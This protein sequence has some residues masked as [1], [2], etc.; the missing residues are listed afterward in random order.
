MDLVRFVIAVVKQR[1]YVD[2]RMDFWVGIV[3]TVGGVG[4]E[5]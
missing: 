1:K 5:K 3:L 4:N 2:V